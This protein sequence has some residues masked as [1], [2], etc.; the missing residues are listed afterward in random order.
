VEFKQQLQVL[1]KLGR[2]ILWHL[3]LLVS[4]ACFEPDVLGISALRNFL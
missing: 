3:V 4:N 1:A 2:R